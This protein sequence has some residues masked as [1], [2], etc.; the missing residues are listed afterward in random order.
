LPIKYQNELKRFIIVKHK[1]VQ[2]LKIYEDW[3]DRP[4]FW[5]Y[6]IHILAKH[7]QKGI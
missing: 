7:T 2:K 5:C 3:V 4:F 6:N 1:D